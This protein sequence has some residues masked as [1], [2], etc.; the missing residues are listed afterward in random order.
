MLLSTITDLSGLEEALNLLLR[1]LGFLLGLNEIFLSLVM[2]LLRLSL[3]LL[4]HL[5]PFVR[6]LLKFLVDN[7]ELLIRHRESLEVFSILC[8]VF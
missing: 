7:D 3:S 1:L 8:S 4:E 6:R 5:F 2:E